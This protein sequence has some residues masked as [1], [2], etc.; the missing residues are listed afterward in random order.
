MAEMPVSTLLACRKVTGR[1]TVQTQTIWNIQ[2]ARNAQKLQ[3][4]KK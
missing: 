1:E 3:E 2:K 4:G